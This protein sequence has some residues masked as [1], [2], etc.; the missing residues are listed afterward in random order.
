[1]VTFSPRKNFQTLSSFSS[2]K[3]TK[4]SAYGVFSN[5]WRWA[6]I[7]A[8]WRKRNCSFYSFDFKGFAFFFLKWAA[9]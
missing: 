4:G 3:G 9:N 1:M 2:D 6:T 7:S 8:T 5:R